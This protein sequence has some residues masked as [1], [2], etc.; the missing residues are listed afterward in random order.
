MP[1]TPNSNITAS[2]FTT[3]RDHYNASLTTSNNGDYSTQPQISTSYTVGNEI[4]AAHIN[5][6]YTKINDVSKHCICNSEASCGCKDN[7]PARC[8]CQSYCVCN[9]VGHCPCNV[10]CSCQSQQSNV[11]LATWSGTISGPTSWNMTMH[12]SGSRSGEITNC[13]VDYDIYPANSSWSEQE[14]RNACIRVSNNSSH[15]LLVYPSGTSMY[16]MGYKEEWYERKCYVYGTKLEEHDTRYTRS[17]LGRFSDVCTRSRAQFNNLSTFRLVCDDNSITNNI[18]I[19]A[20][21]YVYGT[22]R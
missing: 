6:L 2:D 15:G 10:Q 4:S 21:I 19:T 18:R 17:K 20:T 3:I 7:C 22:L 8:D 14:F 16:G 5:E 9:C 11:L 1:V 13:R 12:Q